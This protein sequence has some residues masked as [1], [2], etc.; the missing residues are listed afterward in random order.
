MGGNR[1][2]ALVGQ[3]GG[4]KAGDGIGYVVFK[5]IVGSLAAMHDLHGM[6]IGLRDEVYYFRGDSRNGR[7]VGRFEINKEWGRISLRE[8]AFQEDTVANL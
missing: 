1:R 5:V 3:G 6:V 8:L 4:T 7:T 2:G